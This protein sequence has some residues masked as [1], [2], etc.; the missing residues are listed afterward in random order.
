MVNASGNALALKSAIPLLLRRFVTFRFALPG[1]K[2]AVDPPQR[3]LAF[4][5]KL[6][7]ERRE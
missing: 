5:P 1:A 3:G 6:V 7:V 2:L 4:Q